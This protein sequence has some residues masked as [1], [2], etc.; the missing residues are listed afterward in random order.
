MGS[1]VDVKNHET[2]CQQVDGTECH[3]QPQIVHMHNRG[4]V[5]GYE[6]YPQY[7]QGLLTLL[8]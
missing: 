6:A 3:V 2:Q 4:R 8:L 1:H 7:P 5:R